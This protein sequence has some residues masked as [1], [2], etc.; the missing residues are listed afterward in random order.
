[1]TSLAKQLAT[2]HVAQSLE[3]LRDPEKRERW[4]NGTRAKEQ[5]AAIV[6]RIIAD[7]ERRITEEKTHNE[8]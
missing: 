1:M 2:Q 7:A 3:E 8:S 4:L 5:A 6:A